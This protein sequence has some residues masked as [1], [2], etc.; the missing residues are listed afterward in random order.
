LWNPILEQTSELQAMALPEDYSKQAI[1]QWN[2][3]QQEQ[4]A[5]AAPPPSAPTEP[6]PAK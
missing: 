6:A 3:R 5:A 1:D 2:K 4:A